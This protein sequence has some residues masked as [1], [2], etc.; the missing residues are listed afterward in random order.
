MSKYIEIDGRKLCFSSIN[1]VKEGVNL[2]PSAARNNLLFFDDLVKNTNIRWTLFYGTLLGV[3][4]DND[5]IP[6]DDDIDIGVLNED[7]PE[8]MRLLFEFIDNGFVLL[9]NERSILTL[10]RNGVYMDIYFYRRINKRRGNDSRICAYRCMPAAWIEE[11][12]MHKFCGRLIPV[13]VHHESVLIF[14]YG[15]SWTT[16]KKRSYSNYNS[17]LDLIR[18][19]IPLKMVYW[20]PEWVR[21][22]L[23]RCYLMWKIV[24]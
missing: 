5:F 17:L 10:Y 6:H 8:F 20:L 24:F 3:I 11:T 21:A 19:N 22:F 4:R 12:K 18:L 1:I 7:R 13:P 14:L 23:Q 2:D 9:R 15:E 16:P